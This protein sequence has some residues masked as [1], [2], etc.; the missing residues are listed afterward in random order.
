MDPMCF[1][2][3]IPT[4]ELQFLKWV[5]LTLPKLKL[6]NP[7]M[8]E[9]SKFS[10]AKKLPQNFAKLLDFF[11]H[12]FSQSPKLAPNF[13]SQ[14]IKLGNSPPQS[15][16]AVPVVHAVLEDAMSFPWNRLR[17]LQWPWTATHERSLTW[18]TVQSCL[19]LLLKRP[20]S[21]VRVV[22]F[23]VEEKQSHPKLLP[24]NETISSLASHKSSNL[25]E[26][27]TACQIYQYSI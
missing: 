11:I 1:L 6:P 18:G 13:V 15:G 7:T 5:P 12:C 19:F 16:N 21:C 22:C 2:C 3:G 20:E 14:P 4:V 24:K 26:I 23:R 9:H 8:L 10:D 17:G 25:C 27:R